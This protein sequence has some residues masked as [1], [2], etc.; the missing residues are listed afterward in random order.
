MINS[1][2]DFNAKKVL[3]MGLG[4]KG[5]GVG[6]VKFAYK[7]GSEITV[8]D[9]NDKN[10]LKE[11]LKET[12]NI[13]K[14]LVLGKHLE[15]DFITNDIIIK[16]PGIKDDNQ[17]LK[18]AVEKGMVIDTP[19]GIFSEINDMP[20][21]GITGTKGKS[22]TTTL[23]NHILTSLNIKSVA[24]A[25]NCVSPLSYLNQDYTFVLELSSWQLKEMAKHQKSPNISCWLNFFPDHMNYY[26]SL[27]EY[28]NDKESILKYQTEDDFC[29]LPANDK[30]L[31][32]LKCNGKKIL[33]AGDDVYLN[34]VTEYYG[35]C[36]I[37]NNDIIIREENE[38]KKLLSLKDI[39][40]NSLIPHYL[41][42]LIA[43]ITTAYFFIKE[44]RKDITLTKECFINAINS[45]PGLE[46]RYETIVDED[47]FKVINDSSAST[48]N[49]VIRA[50][51]A[52]KN[53]QLVL[54]AGGGGHKNLA[55]DNLVKKIIDNVIYV[56]LFNNDS[57]SAIIKKQFIE[58]D[59]EWFH[60]VDTLKEAVEKAFELAENEG[61][62]LLSPACSGSPFYRDMFERGDLFKKYVSENLK[63]N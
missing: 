44:Y 57:T 24:A 8:T 32:E 63:Q 6:S 46:N 13:P 41:D 37:R 18:L 1:V 7:H 9:L 60:T 31:S 14:K 61:V 30:K 49:S 5:G 15:N 54:I 52:T 33:F 40:P 45:F 23:T 27:D 12:E 29:I 28:Y 10:Y 56:L 2:E 16:N 25:N 36:F 50:I 4:T 11:S 3:V 17:Y 59:Y 55:F 22:Y 47:N 53:R 34:D 26:S 42:L 48:P 62:I 51:E 43:S 38:D 35:A 20:Y 39:N 58:S 19:I 21:V